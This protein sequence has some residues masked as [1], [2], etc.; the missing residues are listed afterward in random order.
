MTYT[1]D[2]IAGYTQEKKELM[3]LCDMFKNRKKYEIAG[4]PA[5]GE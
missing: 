4:K 2:S 3:A 5:K 1:F